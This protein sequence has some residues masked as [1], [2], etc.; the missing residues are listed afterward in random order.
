MNC[1]CHDSRFRIADGGVA[2]GP[3]GRPLPA[4]N[5]TVDGGAIH[6]A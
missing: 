1:P 5:V 6:L 2:N 3:A 4:V